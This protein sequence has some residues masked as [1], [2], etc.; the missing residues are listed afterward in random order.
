MSNEDLDPFFKGVA[1]ISSV[2]A[3]IWILRVRSKGSRALLMS[4]A[5]LILGTTAL[6]IVNRAPSA[7]INT[8]IGITI[9]LLVLEFVVRAKQQAEG[10][11]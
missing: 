8:G 9:G 4:L 1:A 6:L 3:I 10:P 7:L 2:I 11:K 5:F